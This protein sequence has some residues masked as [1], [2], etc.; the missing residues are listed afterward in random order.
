[1]LSGVL[2][3]P[4]AIQVHI[5]IIRVFSKMKE[6]LLD[7][8]DIL[9]KLEKLEKDVKENKEDIALIFNALKKLLNPQQ[10][11]RKRI[12]FKPDY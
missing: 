5:Q 12:G 6:M 10:Q 9:L 2:N 7:N 1:M 11:P 4:L 3:S 8:K